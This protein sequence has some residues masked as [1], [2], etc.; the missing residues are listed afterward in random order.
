M[1]ELAKVSQRM[2]RIQGNMEPIVNLHQTHQYDRSTFQ[3]IAFKFKNDEQFQV[4]E[5]ACIT[6]G[7][8]Q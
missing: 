4:F 2:H 6:M 3:S 8:E 1:Q 5:V 7:L